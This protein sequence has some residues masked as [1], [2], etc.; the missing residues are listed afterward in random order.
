MKQ[1]L[2][3]LAVALFAVGCAPSPSAPAP[4]ATSTAKPIPGAQAR[5]VLSAASRA[6][7]QLDISAQLLDGNGDGIPNVAVAF[8]IPGG[9]IT[10]QT[11][12][13]DGSGVARAVAIASGNTTLSATTGALTSQVNIIGGAT[14]LSVSLSVPSVVV[15]TASAFA[16]NVTGAAVGGP[17]TYVWTYGDGTSSTGAASSSTHTYPGTGSYAAN[18]K[19]TDGAGRTATATASALVTDPIVVVTP[20]VSTPTP[21][22][23]VATL[24]CTANA[25]LT[26][27]PCNVSM[28]YNGTAVASTSVT[29]VVWDWG[30]GSTLDNA[31]VT[32]VKSHS[33]AQAGTYNVTATVTATV[34]GVS[35]TAPIVSKTLTVS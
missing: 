21:T 33:Y 8:T 2:L 1:R 29:G 6:D 23:P 7:Q 30:D 11:T 12:P 3:A 31:S 20:P 35:I 4:V 9:T 5:L 27:S 14:P 17:F 32:P 19:V 16:A 25:P 13:T 15:N 10:P 18:V 24:T 22:G 26:A 28:S 34:G